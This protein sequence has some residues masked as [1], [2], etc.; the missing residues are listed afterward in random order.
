M[1]GRRLPDGTK[2]LSGVQHGD[3]WKDADGMWWA[4][5]PRGSV[6][7]LSDHTVTEHEDGTITVFPSILMPDKWHGYL[8]RGVWREC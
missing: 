4:Y 7:V 1:Q 2:N 3:Y 6:G 5:A 8:E